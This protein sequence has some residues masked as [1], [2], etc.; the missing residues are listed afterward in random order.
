M[1]RWYMQS[2]HLL[3]AFFSLDLYKKTTIVYDGK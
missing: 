3:F 2:E 1:K